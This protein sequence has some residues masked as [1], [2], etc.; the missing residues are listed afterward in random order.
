MTQ[1]PGK[2]LAALAVLLVL[3]S[4]GAACSSDSDDPSGDTMKLS[5]NCSVTDRALSPTAVISEEMT[6]KLL[7]KGEWKANPGLSVSDQGTLEKA[8]VGQC[9]IRPADNE[10]DERLVIEVVPKSEPQYALAR[11][12]LA[13]GEH[14][15]KVDDHTYVTPDPS[16]DSDGNRLEGAKG[17]LINPDYALVVRILHPAKGV[18]ALEQ[19]G[20]TVQAVADNLSHLG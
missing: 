13:S 18:N 15:T 6:E 11:R 5:G 9:G 3:L 2:R 1:A 7:G 20:P 10:N 16:S 8:F 4:T 17:V 12:T 14:I 19:A